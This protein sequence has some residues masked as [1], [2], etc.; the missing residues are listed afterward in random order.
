MIG[1]VEEEEGVEEE[2]N[3]GFESDKFDFCCDFANW[4]VLNS[5]ISS[6]LFGNSFLGGT[7]GLLILPGWNDEFDDLWIDPGEEFPLLDVLPDL[8]LSYKSTNFRFC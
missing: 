6:L 5:K 2:T 4:S 8:L 1:W 7:G 3:N